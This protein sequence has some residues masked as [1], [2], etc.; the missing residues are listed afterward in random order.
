MV[1]VAVRHAAS[2]SSHARW[3][4]RHPHRT[5]GFTA[6]RQNGHPA[7]AQRHNRQQHIITIPD[8]TTW[9]PVAL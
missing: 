2:S 3:R 9:L 7:T 1:A 6:E 8:Q 4:Q 5:R